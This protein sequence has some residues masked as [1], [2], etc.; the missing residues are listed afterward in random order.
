MR[1]CDYHLHS[2]NSCDARSTIPEILDRAIALGMEKICLTDHHDIGY[3]E[4]DPQGYD[5]QLDTETYLAEVR[6]YQEMYKG[7]IDLRLGVELGLMSTVEDEIKAYTK[8]YHDF[9]FIIGSS[10]LVRGADP[11]YPTYY[12][13]RT[14]REAILDYFESILENVT[15]F[16]DF[17]VYGHLDY[18][19]R[20]CPSRM[21]AFIFDHFKDVFAAIFEVLKKKNKGIEINTGGLYKGMGYAHPHMDIL[22]LYK[23]L[24]CEIIT[25]G[26]DAHTPDKI[27]YGFETEA[28][29]MLEAVGFKYFCTFK[30]MEPE[31]NL[32]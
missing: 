6:K 27:G 19:I 14:E 2:I 12:E 13:G 22:K 8:K 30:G 29:R 26:S 25:V 7:K 20:Y 32:L 10:H 17:C 31:F 24:G 18:I 28:R 9:D 16:D 4:N 1:I 23:D 11:Y 3:P 5:F 15:M 21:D